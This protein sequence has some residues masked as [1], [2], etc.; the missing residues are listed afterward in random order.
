MKQQPRR[1][2]CP[3]PKAKKTRKQVTPDQIRAY[4]EESYQ[5]RQ[6]EWHLQLLEDERPDWSSLLGLHLQMTELEQ[7]QASIV[8]LM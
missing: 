4:I 2:Q 7:L 3:S 8:E 6:A 1:P 5:L